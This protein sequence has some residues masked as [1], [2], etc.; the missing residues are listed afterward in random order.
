MTN[1]KVLFAWYKLTLD[2]EPKDRKNGAIVLTDEEHKQVQ[3][4]NFDNAWI[5]KWEG[6]T[7]NATANDVAIE[8]IEIAVERVVM[9]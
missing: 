5:T 3:R 8:T 1:N 4:W 2:G 9:A 6:P 7:L